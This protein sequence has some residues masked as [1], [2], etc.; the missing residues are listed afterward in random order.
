MTT[1][2]PTTPDRGEKKK[3]KSV[4]VRTSPRNLAAKSNKRV[5]GAGKTKVSKKIVTRKVKPNLGCAGGSKKN[6]TKKKTKTVTTPPVEEVQ[7]D[8]DD[9]DEEDLEAGVDDDDNDD[10]D[11][12]HVEDCNREDEDNSADSAPDPIVESE[13]DE[14]DSSDDEEI[15]ITSDHRGT[16]TSFSKLNVE[17]MNSR[18]NYGGGGKGG[19]LAKKPRLL[20]VGDPTD[21]QTASK[22]AIPSELSGVDLD[23]MHLFVHAYTRKE[24]ARY[25]EPHVTTHVSSYVKNVMFRKIK[26]V[27]SEVMIQRAMNSL[28]KFENVKEHKKLHFHRVYE[29]VFNDA[30][31]TKR[32]ACE[33]AGG[34]IVKEALQSMGPDRS[35]FTVEELCK[36]RRSTTEREIH[37][38][39]WFFSTFLECVCGKK[40]WGSAKYNNLVSKASLSGATAGKK[41]NTAIL[42]SKFALNDG[43][44]NQVK[45]SL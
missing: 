18:M 41:E 13:G 1:S 21:C 31:N 28:F 44:H 4:A 40:A 35:L 19:G 33:Q 2:T 20:R 25:R 16:K 8:D 12:F 22:S 23:Q 3:V 42:L 27:N 29:T 43:T 14:D 45:L 38:F 34:K 30:L 15:P 26:F 39:Y 17:K 36:L 9:N 32:S 10:D 7:E 5:V 11:E 6:S 24:S 37:A